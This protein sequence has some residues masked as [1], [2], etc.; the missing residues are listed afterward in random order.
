MKGFLIMLT[1]LTRIPIK[2]P[3]EFKEED[4]TK[5]IVFMPI[6]GLLVGGILFTVGLLDNYIDRPILALLIVTAYIFL[7]GGLHIDGFADTIDGIFSHREQKRM[8]EIMKDSRIGTFGVIGIVLLLLFMIGL[9][10]Y[11]DLKYLLLVATVGRSCGLFV[12]SISKYARKDGLGKKFID[13]CGK[14]EALIALVLPVLIS[15]LLFP[16]KAL[17]PIGI[18]FFASLHITSYI[19]D[20]LGGMTGDT[21]GF[22]I[23]GSQMVYMF[24]LYV[25]RGW[26]G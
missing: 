21:I 11:M 7:T 25:L 6:I 2:Y 4:F 8:L 18:A 10:T 19:K 13:Y 14:R 3:F 26:I 20:K 23:E 24:G 22:V 9:T 16:V 17:I 15:L 1:F 12:S 5:A